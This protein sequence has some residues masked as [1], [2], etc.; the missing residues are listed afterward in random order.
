MEESLKAPTE[1]MLDEAE[2]D[3][4]TEAEAEE[5]APCSADDLPEDTE[6]VPPPSVEDLQKEVDTLRAELS[7]KEDMERRRVQEEREFRLLYPEVDMTVLPDSVW[8]NVQKGVP[9]AAAYALFERIR[10]CTEQK[11]ASANQANRQRAAGA[12]ESTE[13]DYFSPAEVRRMS[14]SEV[15]ANYSKIMRSMQKWH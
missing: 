8:E 9:L 4:P 15:R 14:A 13:S 5:L 6:Q 11:A 2:V 12:I 1:A 10:F 7:K 3:E